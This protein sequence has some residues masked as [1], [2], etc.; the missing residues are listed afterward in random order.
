MVCSRSESPT[1]HTN[2]MTENTSTI[3][4]RR[5]PGWVVSSA[6]II[7]IFGLLQVPKIWRAVGAGIEAGEHVCQQVYD[8][9]SLKSAFKSM[10]GDKRFNYPKRYEWIATSIMKDEMSTCPS[11]KAYFKPQS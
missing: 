6:S 3:Q 9:N 5:I 1:H 2:Q 11:L 4:K 8:G 7:T 10:E